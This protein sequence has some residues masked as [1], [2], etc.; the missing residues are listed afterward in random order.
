M[1]VDLSTISIAQDHATTTTM[2]DIV[3]LLN[4]METH[5]GAT[6]HYLASDMIF[7]VARNASY[8]CEE[9]ARIQDG[10]HFP[11]TYQLIKNGDKPSTLP[12]NNA[13]I[14]NLFKLIKTLMYSAV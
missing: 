11:L 8:L 2:G 10:S 9:R 13:V 5:L 1:L 12:T 14:N 4:Y 6:L 3:W 7:Y